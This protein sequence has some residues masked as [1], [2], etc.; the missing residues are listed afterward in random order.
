MRWM[1]RSLLA[2]LVLSTPQLAQA[3]PGHATEVV[4]S[5]SAWHYL[6]QPEHALANLF[7]AAVIGFCC[8]RLIHHRR[9]KLL[10]ARVRRS[11]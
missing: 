9:P 5:S 1:N 10:L 2:C 11:S 6:V 8:I 7:L 4:S 3:H